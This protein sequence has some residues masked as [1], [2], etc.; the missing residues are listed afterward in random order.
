MAGILLVDYAETVFRAPI[1]TAIAL[2]VL[3]I[4]L[5]AVDR[6]MPRNRTIDDM[7]WRDAL[8]VGFAQCLALVPGVSR[9]GATITAGRALGIDR[10][11]AAVFSFLM[12]M[13]IIAAA[14]VFK[15]PDAIAEQGIT[16]PLVVGVSSAAVSSWMAIAFL[17]RYVSRRDYGIF[18]VY[19][20]LFGGLVLWLLLNQAS[21]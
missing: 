8:V 18:A 10:Q 4:I 3:G 7:G 1:I 11:G 21:L 13:P 16:L 2:I 17:I 12:S 9:S 14:A 15:V 19:R 20:V 5:W 6:Y